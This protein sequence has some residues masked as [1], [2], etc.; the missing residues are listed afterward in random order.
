MMVQNTQVTSSIA[1]HRA[2]IVTFVVLHPASLLARHV[3]QCTIPSAIIISAL[4]VASESPVNFGVGASHFLYNHLC[5]ALAS[6]CL[7][8]LELLALESSKRIEDSS[9]Q[10]KDC[11]N[12]QACCHGYD[13]DPLYCT[14]GEIDSGAHVVRT[15]FANEGIELGGG[16]ADAEEE[17]YLDED[18]DEGAYQADNAKSDHEVGVEDVGNS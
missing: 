5:N 17:G 13:A 6:Q 4:L 8:A 3:E 10:Q 7:A 2:A 12:N 15:E 1:D 18:D 14:H 11:R 16:W 9:D